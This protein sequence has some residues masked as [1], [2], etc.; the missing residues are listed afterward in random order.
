MSNRRWLLYALGNGWGHLNRSL[1][2]GRLAAHSRGIDIICNSGY[3]YKLNEFPAWQDEKKSLDIRIVNLSGKAKNEIHN[4]VEEHI[5]WDEYECVLVDTFPRGITGELVTVLPRLVDLRR[6]L[7]ARQLKKKYLAQF[8]L[9]TFVR[10]NF[11]EVI[12]PG[13]NLS[14]E[15]QLDVSFETPHWLIRSHE[16]LPSRRQMRRVLGVSHEQSFVVVVA[17]GLREE[18]EFYGKLTN[19]VAERLPNSTVR[20]LSFEQPNSIPPALW[21]NHWPGIEVLAACDIAIGGAGYNTM[22]ECR[23]L[24]VPLIAIP[25]ARTYD[26]QSMR[27]LQCQF[28][29]EDFN[30]VMDALNS[31]KLKTALKETNSTVDIQSYENGAATAVR[32]LGVEKN[33]V[34]NV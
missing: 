30:A 17:S 2:L 33:H 1:A 5:S 14:E 13:E 34:G 11:E 23:A 12:N 15:Q 22:S 32:F 4:F 25:Q 20:C 8:D 27:A 10:D 19:H 6:I 26:T 28:V 31:S 18:T 9:P 29:A 3:A 24:N 21:I 16:E 7:V